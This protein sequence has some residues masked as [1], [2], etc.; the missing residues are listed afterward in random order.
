[1][2]PSD[3]K[4]T[5]GRPPRLASVFSNYHRPVYFVTF[6]TLD[7][8]NVLATPDVHDAFCRYGVCGEAHGAAVGRYV[9]MPDHV[10][11]FV[12]QSVDRSLGTWVKGLKRS[13]ATPLQDAIAGGRIWQPGFFDHLLRHGESYAA[14][15]EYVRQ[16]P[17]RRGLVSC[18][19]EWPFSGEIVPISGV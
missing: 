13:M 7:R 3:S 5:P 17:V 18:P 10:H 1:M 6:C 15:W 8:R 12:R 9:I 11:L 19:E 2:K 4:Q 14:K 16:N